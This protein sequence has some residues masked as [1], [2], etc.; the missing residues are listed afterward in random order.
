LESEEEEDFWIFDRDPEEDEESESEE[1]ED[2]LIFD[3]CPG[4]D[5][6]SGSESEPERYLL[7]DS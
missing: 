2:F 6:E 5:E 7:F 3:R 4:E 1:E